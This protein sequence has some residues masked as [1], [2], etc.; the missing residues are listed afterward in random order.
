MS[1]VKPY[2][3]VQLDNGSAA[4]DIEATTSNGWFDELPE[5]G[6]DAIRAV[7]EAININEFMTSAEG[8]LI[9]IEGPVRLFIYRW[10][11][12]RQ[13]EEKA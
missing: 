4:I 11:D 10:I 1:S 8:H 3:L 13:F 2:V 5:T 9:L 7:R 12:S 6:S